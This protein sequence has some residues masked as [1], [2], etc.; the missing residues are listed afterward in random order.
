[1]GSE[2]ELICIYLFRLHWASAAARRLRSGGGERGYTSSRCAVLSRLTPAVEHR[3]QGAQARSFSS[4]APEHRLR[5]G[6]AR[7]ELLCGTWDLPSPRMEP[8]SPTVAGGF[9]PTGP[10]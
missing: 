10:P 9:L 5:S 3:P 7:A 6:G 8:V 1:M 2:E 4:R